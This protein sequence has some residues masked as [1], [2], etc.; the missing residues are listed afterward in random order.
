MPDI[1]KF[2][3][4]LLN[5]APEILNSDLVCTFFHPILRDQ[6]DADIHVK[7]VKENKQLPP[8]NMN[9]EIKFSYQYHRETLIVMVSLN[10]F[11]FN[12]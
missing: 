10:F 2:V 6:Q 11:F 8:A 3:I 12:I 5:S 1:K 9:G 7:K 4:S